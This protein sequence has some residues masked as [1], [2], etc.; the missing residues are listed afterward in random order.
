MQYIP[1]SPRSIWVGPL[2]CLG[3]E[4][5][6]PWQNPR[7]KSE[8]PQLQGCRDQ[9]SEK[10]RPGGFACWVISNSLPALLPESAGSRWWRQSRHRSIKWNQHLKTLIFPL[11]THAPPHSQLPLPTSKGFSKSLR[12]RRNISQTHAP[13]MKEEARV[14]V[15]PLSITCSPAWSGKKDEMT[16][17]QLPICPE[18]PTTQGWQRA[19][20]SWPLEPYPLHAHGSASPLSPHKACFLLSFGSLE[21]S[22]LMCTFHML[23]ISRETARTIS[24]CHQVAA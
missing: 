8:Q 24:L 5:F 17:N 18:S 1:P 14:K 11:P 16:G 9:D 22:G 12:Q 15:S 23:T 10:A 7:P 6:F 13:K 20:S 21:F 4:K 2:I 3:R 19:K